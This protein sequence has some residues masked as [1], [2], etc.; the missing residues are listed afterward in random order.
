MTRRALVSARPRI[1]ASRCIATLCATA[2]LAAACGVRTP[3]RPP[4][5]TQPR[6]ATDVDAKRD[7][8]NVH[9]QWERPSESVDGHRLADL[10][11]FLVE[12]RTGDGAFTIIANVP[13][14]TE[15][16]LRPRKHYDY[17]DT[18]PPPAPIEYRVVSYA[19]DGQRSAPSKSAFIEGGATTP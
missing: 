11:G 8:E 10:T 16:R 2:V 18:A 15:H 3:P 14:D 7:G 12:R 6:V 17:T 19:S 1:V 9:L 4:E 13:A 5:D